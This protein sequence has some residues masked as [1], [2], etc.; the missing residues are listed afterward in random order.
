VPHESNASPTPA[1]DPPNVDLVVTIVGWRPLRGRLRRGGFAPQPEHDFHGWSGLAAAL[2]AIER[3][4][5]R[6]R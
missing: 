1:E 2:V 6:S 4:L 3:E 5:G